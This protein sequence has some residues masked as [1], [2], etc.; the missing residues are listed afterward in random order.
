MSL[1]NLAEELKR[2][3]TVRSMVKETILAGAPM[4]IELVLRR[5][6]V[7]DIPDFEIRS[8]IRRLQNSGDIFVNKDKMLAMV[9]ER[10]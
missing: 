4:P 3:V 5:L 8:A 7:C 9:W 6:S 1:R 10:L 2:R